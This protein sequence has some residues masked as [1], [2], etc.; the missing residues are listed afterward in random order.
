MPA[1]PDCLPADSR[2]CFSSRGRLISQPKSL[3][4]LLFS[5]LISPIYS[6]T[7]PLI[8][9]PFLVRLRHLSPMTGTSKARTPTIPHLE[10]LPLHEYQPNLNKKHPIVKGSGPKNRG[11]P[12]ILKYHSWFGSV[13]HC[14]CWPPWKG[15]GARSETTTHSF[16]H[17]IPDQVWNDISRSMLRLKTSVSPRN[18]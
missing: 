8:H 15:N 10:L 9:P 11:D 14:F 13:R 5:C 1:L 7:H 2:P 3:L 18:R 12:V 6:S 16:F 4:S 17:W